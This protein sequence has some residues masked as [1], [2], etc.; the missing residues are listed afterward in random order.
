MIYLDLFFMLF[1]IY[2]P[3]INYLWIIYFLYF[4]DLNYLFIIYFMYRINLFRNNFT[5]IIL[6]QNPTY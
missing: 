3:F 6:F 1:L 2:N 5:I 4:I